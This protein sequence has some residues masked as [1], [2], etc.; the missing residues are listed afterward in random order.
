M[1]ALCSVT[2]Q[3]DFVYTACIRPRNHPGPHLDHVPD[4][5][6]CNGRIH[7]NAVH[8]PALPV[9]DPDNGVW[10]HAGH[11]WARDRERTRLVV[12]A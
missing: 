12:A 6:W 1:T 11:L 5:P 4:C 8:G 2:V 7:P 3:A 9:Q 10:W